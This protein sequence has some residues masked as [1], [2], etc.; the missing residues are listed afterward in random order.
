M[1]VCFAREKTFVS[2]HITLRSVAARG[3]TITTILMSKLFSVQFTGCPGVIA[4][5]YSSSLLM[6][7]F[8]LAGYGCM[9]CTGKSGKAVAGLNDRRDYFLLTFFE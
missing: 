6:V 7:L 4:R 2:R 3:G 1:D 9:F 8:L 5:V